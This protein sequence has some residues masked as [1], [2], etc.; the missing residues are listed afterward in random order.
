MAT[1]SEGP[2]AAV[3]RTAA[4]KRRAQRKRRTLAIECRGPG[5]LR[6]DARTI[7]VS[8]GGTLIEIAD[9]TIFST[10]RPSPFADRAQEI[11]ALFPDGID[12]SFGEGAVLAFA[13]IV[14]CLSVPD[15]GDLV[16]LGCKFEPALS[17]VDC[18]L[19]GIEFDADETGAGDGAGPSKAVRVDGDELVLFIEAKDRNWTGSNVPADATPVVAP[20]P[21]PGRSPSPLVYVEK[22][23]STELVVRSAA[24]SPDA[25]AEI[26]TDLERALG[27][28]AAAA[29]APTPTGPAGT[30]LADDDLR[31]MNR[32]KAR[33]IPAAVPGKA[34]DW[35]R[36]AVVVYLFP[37]MAGASAPRYHG[38]LATI[39]RDHVDVD[40]PVPA[41]DVDA[42]GHGAGLG[43]AVRAVFVLDGRVLAELACDV[44]R[45]DVPT[46]GC[47]RARMRTGS[48]VPPGLIESAR[49]TQG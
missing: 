16:L 1:H 7:D 46:Q 28:G 41:G 6:V 4:G 49:G 43:A 2:D 39:D 42:I 20:P 31:R 18:R 25:R 15:R 40:L 8:R 38:R 27:T 17:P 5:G 24:P 10:E 44:V 34:S 32:G 12:V 37:T 9:P 35:A 47:V 23:G 30:G 11:R 48:A 21:V 13:R 22:A 26:R 45:L 3:E 19:L 33:A 36:G 29:V 14:R